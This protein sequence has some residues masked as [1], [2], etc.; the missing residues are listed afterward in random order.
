MRTLGVTLHVMMTCMLFDDTHIHSVSQ[1]Q[2][3]GVLYPEGLPPLSELCQA[4]ITQLLQ[5]SPASRPSVEQM[6]E[7]RSLMQDI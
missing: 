2:K 6:T 1:Q 4:L 5:F 7:N 3:K